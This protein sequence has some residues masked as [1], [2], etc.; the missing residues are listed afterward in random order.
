MEFITGAVLIP[1]PLHKKKL[2]KRSFNQSVWIAEALAKEAD[3]S[4]VAYDCMTRIR[5]TSS[6]TKLD[7]NQRGRMLKMLL[8]S[9]KE[10]VWMG[11]I[12]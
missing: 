6:Q 9:K 5:N 7:R 3:V 10:L 2:H 1:V 12:E 11:L 8:P 4:T